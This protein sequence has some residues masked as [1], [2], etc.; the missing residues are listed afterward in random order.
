MAKRYFLKP[1]SVVAGIAAVVF[2][3][4]PLRT[5]TQVLL[6]SGSLAIALICAAV[7]GSLNDEHTGYWPD[8][9]KQ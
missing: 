7:S 3:F 2:F 8:K 4:M 1:I 6:C 5:F 9:P